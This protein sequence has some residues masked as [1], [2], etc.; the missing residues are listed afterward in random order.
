MESLW[1]SH[2][3]ITSAFICGLCGPHFG[4]TMDLWSD[5][6]V[7]KM[8]TTQ[9]NG[10]NF[11]R[12]FRIGGGYQRVVPPITPQPQDPD[13]HRVEPQKVPLD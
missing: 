7:V 4:A 11:A 13:F 6:E 2:L 1:G 12:P 5:R 8:G 3:G 10:S 9:C